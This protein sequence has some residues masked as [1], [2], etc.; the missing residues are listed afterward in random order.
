MPVI[1]AFAATL[2]E[3]GIGTTIRRNRGQEVGA[4]CGQLAAERAGEPPAPAVARRR[5][6]LVI[7]SAAALRGDRSD[8]PRPG[9][10]ARRGRGV[11]DVGDR[12]RAH[13]R[14]HP[15]RRPGEP[16]LR[17][18]P[19][20]DGRRRPGPP[21]RHGRPLRPEPDVRRRRRSRPSGART[22]LPFDAHLM[23]SEPGRYIEEFLDAGCDSIT[24]HVEIDEPIEPTLRRDPG[25]RPGGRPGASSRHA[26]R[27]PLEP[28]AAAA[29]H[30]DGH[31]RRARVRRP[32]VHAR[33][34]AGQ[35]RPARDLL[36]PPAV[37]RRGPRR[38]RDQPRDGRVSPA[39]R[40][41]RPR[42][43]ARRCSS[44]A[45]TWAARSGSIRALADEGYQ[46]GLNEGV[47]PIP[48]DDGPRSPACPST[49]PSDFG[50][51]RGGRH[52]GVML[53]GTGR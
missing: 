4:A 34:P 37:R 36:E 51:D 43:R 48:R 45:A 1:E 11:G 42:R 9:R 41:R 24:F 31:D 46:Y 27:R 3:A 15:R 8:E 38:R 39:A 32:G 13:R 21:R 53:R 19:G 52:P 14:E 2:R 6:R 23:I 40:R 10:R 44:R 5:E 26:A 22:E 47:P 33:R 16:G 29:R 17:R 30:R 49:S 50:R 12:P 20:R 25:R 7:A 18:P 35:G 28:Y